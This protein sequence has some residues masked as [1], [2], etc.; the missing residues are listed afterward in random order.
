MFMSDLDTIKTILDR[1][2]IEFFECGPDKHWKLKT[3][4]VQRGYRGFEVNFSFDEHGN[5]AD[6]GAYE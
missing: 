2:N 4:V 1:A 3:I 6:L 5:L